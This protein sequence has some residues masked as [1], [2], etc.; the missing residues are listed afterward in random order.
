MEYYSARKMNEAR[1]RALMQ[2]DSENIMMGHL[3]DLVEWATHG[4]RDTSLS[5][6]LS[7]EPT[8]L[9][10]EDRDAWMAQRLSVCLQPR[11]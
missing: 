2:L 11:V 5:P 8:F 4:I 7:V 6:M 3:A 1:T 9:K 10:S